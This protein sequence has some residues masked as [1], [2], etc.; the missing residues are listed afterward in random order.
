MSLVALVLAATIPAAASAT[1]SGPDL[2]EVPVGDATVSGP[3]LAV[4]PVCDA[5]EPP[6]VLL[7]QRLATVLAKRGRPTLAASS[8]AQRLLLFTDPNSQSIE[9]AQAQVERAGVAYAAFDLAQSANLLEQAVQSLEVDSNPS[10]EQLELL[11]QTRLQ[12]ADRLLALAGNDETGRAETAS[13]Q[14]ALSYLEAALRAD[15]LLAPPAG[16]YP[17]RLRQLLELGRRNVRAS[18]TGSLTVRSTPPGAVVLLEGRTLGATPLALERSVPRGRYRIWL[19]LGGRC[20]RTRTI[21][22]GDSAISIDVDL[23][24]EGAIDAAN[25]GLC[26]LSGAALTDADLI[27]TGQVIDADLLVATGYADF[28]GSRWIYAVLYDI[29]RGSAVRRGAVRLT[30]AANAGTSEETALADLACFLA[31]SGEHGAALATAPVPI[32][33]LSARAPAG[34]PSPPQVAA[35]DDKGPSWLLPAILGGSVALVAAAAIGSFVAVHALSS[36]SAEPERSL[37]VEVQR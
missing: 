12:L 18:S 21:E 4:V 30:A 32:R 35:A 27:R 25:G 2:A 9:T 7:A 33:E 13:G 22:I 15:P 34:R 19:E 17:P 8:V 23:G 36:A 31:D 20:S 16:V 10:P 28:E 3:D 37:H 26:A 24:F 14:R 1:D 11:Q 29:A 6:P 5:V